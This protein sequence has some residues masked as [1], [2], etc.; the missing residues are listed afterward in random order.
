M[1]N[2]DIHYYYEFNSKVERQICYFSNRSQIKVLC[3]LCWIFL[4]LFVITYFSIVFWLAGVG[5]SSFITWNDAWP[6]VHPSCFVC[7]FFWFFFFFVS[8]VLLLP[9]A[10]LKCNN[11]KSPQSG[12]AHCAHPFISNLLSLIRFSVSFDWRKKEKKI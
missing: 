9:I 5:S 1:L 6:Y 8:L 4:F 7:F 11:V 10:H 2:V 3:C 12:I